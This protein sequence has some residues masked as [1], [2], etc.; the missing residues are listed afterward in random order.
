MSDRPP[1]RTALCRPEVKF[2]RI[3]PYKKG[4]TFN[5][6][7]AWN[8]SFEKT[9]FYVIRTTDKGQRGVFVSWGF[10]Y[11]ENE[12]GRKVQVI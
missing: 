11:V 3:K 12:R 9:G 4:D 10:S 5:W 8:H 2:H 1:I 6:R 7:K